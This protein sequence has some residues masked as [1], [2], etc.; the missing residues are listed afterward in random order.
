MG[1][2]ISKQT[3]ITRPSK[4]KQVNDIGVE[5]EEEDLSTDTHEYSPTLPNKTV[6]IVIGDHLDGSS[7]HYGIDVP[8]FH[9][10]GVHIVGPDFNDYR[11]MTIGKNWDEEDNDIF[12][13][14]FQN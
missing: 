5:E 12:H 2:P 14:D 10:D 3:P 9:Y 11:L 7:I 6:L 8:Q 1:K 13:N 4:D